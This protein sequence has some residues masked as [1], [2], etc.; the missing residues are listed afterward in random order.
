[1]LVLHT[2]SLCDAFE[3]AS[4]RLSFV[5]SEENVADPLTKPMSIS[6]LLLFFTTLSP[7]P[8]YD[9]APVPHAFVL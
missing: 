4:V 9:P 8:S 3:A 6:L 1:M 2:L 5:S 7:R